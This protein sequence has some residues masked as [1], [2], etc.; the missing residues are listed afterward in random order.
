MHYTENKG[1]LFGTAFFAFIA[2]ALTWAFFGD[3]IKNRINQNQTWNELKHKVEDQA[4]KTK[5]LT[6]SQYERIV[7]TT[8]QNYGKIK[9]ISQHELRDLVSD[10][11][12]HWHRIRDAWSKDINRTSDDLDQMSDEQRR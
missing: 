3:K 11:K 12:L 2:G 5:D 6:Q 1:S 7:D 4:R 9:N 8:A 10:L